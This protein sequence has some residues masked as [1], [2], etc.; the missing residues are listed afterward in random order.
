MPFASVE[1]YIQLQEDDDMSESDHEVVVA[2]REL[3]DMGVDT[4]D[5]LYCC[6]IAVDTHE[7]IMIKEEST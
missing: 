4:G 5:L 7:L 3:V 2:L 1:H 6:T